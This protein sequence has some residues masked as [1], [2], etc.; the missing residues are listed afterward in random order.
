VGL[1]TLQAL[2]ASGVRQVFVI[3]ISNGKKALALAL[4]ADAFI[5]PRETEPVKA[6]EELTDGRGVDSAFECVGSGPT[7]QTSVNVTRGGGTICVVGVFP[8]PFEFDWNEVMRREKTMVTTMAYTDEFPTV[9]A[10][11]KD[12]RLKAE[13]LIT[14][15]LPF[16]QVLEAGLKQYEAFSAINVRTVVEIGS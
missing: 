13:P 12:G 3:E 9:I 6:L 8:G 1:C 5:N 15:T 2:R 16:A 14:R 10:M 4:G 11:L 7:L